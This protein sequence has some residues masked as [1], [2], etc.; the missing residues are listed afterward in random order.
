MH[1]RTWYLV[2]FFCYEAMDDV[3]PKHEAFSS[4][5]CFDV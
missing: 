4:T 1:V 2:Q 5:L 3:L